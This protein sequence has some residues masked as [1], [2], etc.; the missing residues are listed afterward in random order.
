MRFW[1]SSATLVT[2]RWVDLSV[3]AEDAGFDGVTVSD[4]I[5]YTTD[6][7]SLY[8][9]SPDGKP[10]WGSMTPW[11]DPWVVIGAMAASTNTL[12]FT[13]NVYV[14]AA[15]DLFTVAKLVSTAA[16]VSGERVS[17]GVGAGWC[18]EEFDQTGQDFAT[19]GQRLEEMIEQLRRLWTGSPV[20]HE[21]RFFRFD[22]LSLA[23]VPAQPIAI[24][25]GG[26]TP[27]A[28]KR[29]AHLGDGWIGVTYS[30]SE[31]AEVV[32]RLRG[33]LRS[34]G[35]E[36]DEGF[37]VMLAYRGELDRA[38]VD[39]LSGFGVTD[40]ITAPWMAAQ[41]SH[42]RLG[43]PHHLVVGSIERFGLEVIT[44]SSRPNG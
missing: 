19:R 41:R 38:V 7:R 40:L 43:I 30:L 15:R 22:E 4:H 33:E 3:A 13:T 34:V 18:R 14:A 11:P 29:A 17:L 25:C 26:D 36:E 35:R 27:P 12:L 42:P 44:P 5:S 37:K 9:G 2:D 28:L 23:P 10:F 16:V 21:G 8:P 32:N 31:A 24:M 39:T 1:F 20:A 6:L